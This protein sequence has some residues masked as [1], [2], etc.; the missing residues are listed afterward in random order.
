MSS[1]VTR[2]AARRSASSC[3]STGPREI[4]G[5]ELRIAA[6]AGTRA[7]GTL[8]RLPYSLSRLVPLLTPSDLTRHVKAGQPS[9]PSPSAVQLALT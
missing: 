5:H 3:K 4:R 8:N 6:L 9:G 1:N 2:P 7:C